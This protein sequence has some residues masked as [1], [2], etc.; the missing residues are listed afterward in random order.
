RKEP[1]MDRAI[2]SFLRA[3]VTLLA[4]GAAAPWAPAAEAPRAPTV[5]DLLNVRQ[6]RGA[7]LSPDGRYVAYSVIEADFE[8]DA[9]VTRL[10]L[11]TSDGARAFQLTTGEK[12]ATSPLWSPDGRWLAF[13]SGRSGDKDQLFVI[14]PEGGEAVRLTRAEE[15]VEAFAWS[16]DGRQIAFRGT[17]AESQAHKDRKAYLGDYEVV[18]HDYKYRQIF[19][20]DV[21]EALKAPVPGVQRTK[22][23]ER[24]VSGFDW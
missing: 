4:L 3:L 5:D 21:A 18:R 1:A 8:Q 23:T 16:R 20:L 13:L 17:E 15:G 12:S 22:G 7:V 24:S 10:W 19:T 2:R 14:A 9:F 6:A 11:A